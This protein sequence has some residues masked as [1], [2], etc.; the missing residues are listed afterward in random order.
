MSKLKHKK[1][2]KI[3][4]SKIIALLLLI[5]ST[6][7]TVQ[8]IIVDIVPTKY[9]IAFIGIMLLINF[10][11][12]LVIFKKSNKKKLKRTV[13]GFAVFF[14]LLF[15]LVYAY[16]LKTSGFLDSIEETGY[17]IENY[18][19]IV[20]ES[21]KYKKLRDI[22]G[23]SVGYYDKTTG[24]KKANKKLG[25]KVDVTF[26][27]FD[28]AASL[29]KQLVDSSSSADTTDAETVLETN[30]SNENEEE[31]LEVIV[32]EDSV[33]SMIKEE[34]PEFEKNTRVIYQFKILIKVK[35]SKKDVDVT[36]KSFNIYISGIDTY[37]EISSVSRSDVNM[38]VTVNPKTKQILLTSIPRDYY[39]KL[40]T[41]KAYDKLTHA[42]MYGVEESIQTIEDLLD[43]DINYYVKVNFTSVV[44]VVNAVG[45]L[46]VY[47]DYS[48]TSEDGFRYTE[49][50]NNVNGEEALSFARERHSFSDGDR[51][52]VKDQQAVLTALIKKVCS[53]S[54]LT[55]YSSIL[56]SLEG[57][58][59]T[60]MSSRKIKSLVKMQLNDMASWTVTSVSL[61]GFDSHDTTYSG[62]SQSLY[63]MEPD[64]SAVSE[65]SDLIKKVIKGKRL[66]GSYE[67]S[68]KGSK[69][70]RNK[71]SNKTTTNNSNVN[72]STETNNKTDN[73]SVPADI[74]CQSG[75]TLS[76]DKTVCTQV[77]SVEPSYSCSSGDLE[78]SYCVVTVCSFE[79]PT[80]EETC[81]DG[82][83]EGGKCVKKTSANGSC[84]NGYNLNGDKC[85]KVASV[86]PSYS[87]PSGYRLSGKTC[88]K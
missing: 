70:S 26:K 41:Y 7:L 79:D 60:N 39:V 72:N 23:L 83:F 28:D 2:K 49:G 14:I 37:G 27:S 42:G 66:K 5:V 11:T 29:S 4:L 17:K 81:T 9:L 53:K 1:K 35:N 76:N 87:C 78:G 13:T 51:Q 47:S 63:V 21:S 75:Y 85:T 15:S 6:L 25:S 8:V 58:F 71:K 12:M 33:L 31:K 80:C 38:V 61:K 65:A 73:S 50:Y 55:K 69:V 48:F 45:G 36:S 54:I 18:S 10:I 82:N 43:I 52:R 59:D 30:Q 46:K 19:V 64:E 44:D 3:S 57:E 77:D 74:T 40:H 24:C 62:G 84:N 16:L 88:V 86:S 56:N 20:K 68:G 34:N 32:V 67:F 22:K